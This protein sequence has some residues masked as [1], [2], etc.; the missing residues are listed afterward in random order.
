[1]P[2]ND[3]PRA[4]PR[5]HG[6]S[7]IGVGGGEGGGGGGHQVTRGRACRRSPRDAGRAT[8]CRNNTGLPY[9]SVSDF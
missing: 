1:M 9:T 5:G 7:A 3:C 8:R 6:Y 2:V 4:R